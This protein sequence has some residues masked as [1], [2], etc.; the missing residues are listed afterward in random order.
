MGQLWGLCNHGAVVKK[1]DHAFGSTSCAV[2]GNGVQPHSEHSLPWGSER[3]CG[4]VRCEFCLQKTSRHTMSVL[5]TWTKMT[6]GSLFSVS[7]AQEGTWNKWWKGWLVPF[8]CSHSP[9]CKRNFWCHLSWWHV[10][11]LGGQPCEVWMPL[12]LLNGC[13]FAPPPRVA[14]AGRWQPWRVKGMQIWLSLPWRHWKRCNRADC[15]LPTCPIQLPGQWH[16]CQESNHSQQTG[17]G[18]V[19]NLMFSASDVAIPRGHRNNW[20]EMCWNS[21]AC[22]HA[23]VFRAQRFC[24]CRSPRQSYFERHWSQSKMP[25]LGEQNYFGCCPTCTTRRKLLLPV[26]LQPGDSQRRPLSLQWKCECFYVSVDTKSR[27]KALWKRSLWHANI[28]NVCNKIKSKLFLS[29]HQKCSE[30]HLLHNTFFQVWKWAAEAGENHLDLHKANNSNNS[31]NQRRTIQPTQLCRW[32]CLSSSGNSGDTFH[33]FLNQHLGQERWLLDSNS[34]R[35]RWGGGGGLNKG[36]ESNKFC[37][38]CASGWRW[39]QCSCERPGAGAQF[40]WVALLQIYGWSR[41]LRDR[42][43]PFIFGCPVIVLLS[44]GSSERNWASRVK[45][46]RTQLSVYNRKTQWYTGPWLRRT[47]VFS[48]GEGGRG[49]VNPLM[50]LINIH[51]FASGIWECLV[52]RRCSDLGY[53][54]HHFAKQTQRD[55]TWCG[56]GV[57]AMVCTHTGANEDNSGWPS[58]QVIWTGSVLFRWFEPWSIHCIIYGDGENHL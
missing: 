20:K 12:T 6:L 13:L 40:V 46:P 27:P 25:S 38:S 56:A 28:L 5:I 31:W 47:P 45:F 26:I 15:N 34:N 11:D 49:P 50:P 1:G 54:C 19:Y 7:F 53:S 4:G 16:R 8:V 24:S 42:W 22:G 55:G 48:F 41:K 57:H 29:L 23:P 37:A 35:V 18:R 44:S 32:T 51:L 36:S 30:P 52:W 3:R 9:H 21:L 39:G 2:I 43:Y 17:R 33:F 10:F 58:D 14:H